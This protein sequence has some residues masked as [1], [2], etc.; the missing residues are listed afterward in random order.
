M[1][2]GSRFES[3]AGRVTLAT[4]MILGVSTGLAVTGCGTPAAPQPPSLD[5]PQPVSDLTAHRDGNQVSLA[6][7]MPRKNT[8]KL[9]LKRRL[10]VLVW[11][12]VQ[13][14]AHRQPAGAAFAL[15]PGAAGSYTDMLPAAL[16]S[17]PP[18]PLRYFV[19][20][21]NRRGRS[22][23]LSNAALV[24]AGQAPAPVTG[25]SAAVRKQG[26]VLRWAPMTARQS[27]P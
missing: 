15:A 4:A 2:A 17:G 6:W 18:R 1:K 25:F 16:A 19:E 10:T 26:V 24:L 11:R 14:S 22:A 9:Y 13:G 21:E 12:Q 27:S 20:I 7:T 23:G 3:L 5:L 8:D